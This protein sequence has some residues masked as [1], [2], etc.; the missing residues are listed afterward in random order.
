MT[1]EQINYLESFLSVMT[2]SER[3]HRT[4][5]KA[6]YDTDFLMKTFFS[7]RMTHRGKMIESCDF[8]HKIDIAYQ[9]NTDVN[10]IAPR[11]HAKTTRIIVN[12]FRDLA[13]GELIIW[14]P[15][16]LLYLSERW[17]GE[18]SI[19]RL[20]AELETNEIIRDV[21]WVLAPN[22]ADSKYI[23]E[24]SKKKRKQ[25]YLELT[26][27]ASIE[28]VSKWWALR[29]RRKHKVI[30]DDLEENK[31][32]KNLRVVEE[33]RDFMLTTVYNMMLP[34]GSM[35]ILGTIVGELCFVLYLKQKRAKAFNTLIVY[36]IQD[37]KPIRPAM[38]SKAALRKRL[39]TI[40][41]ARFMQEFMHKPISVKDRIIK[42]H[43]IKYRTTDTLPNKFDK[44][45]MGIDIATTEKKTS[46]ETAVTVLWFIFHSNRWVNYYDVYVL[47]NDGRKLSP[48]KTELMI[49]KKY[50]DRKPDEIYYEENIEA[51]LLEDLK[52][53][54]LPI[55]W[56]RTAK[57]KHTR[58]WD[59]APDI[60]FG[61]VFFWPDQKWLTDQL[62]YFPDVEHDDRMDSFLIALKRDVK[63][64]NDKVRA[65]S[66]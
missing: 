9:S 21:Y 51:K 41:S 24:N 1:L 42:A 3:R 2:R 26:N 31:D 16:D 14:E 29:G 35:F 62:T 15:Y 17:L 30:G 18:I 27:G 39:E 5:C 7:K 56:V 53:R 66:N 22:D 59:A 48:W 36:A 43:R 20:R 11:W 34:W 33:F 50:M 63:K 25:S 10:L 12:M 45:I 8:H 44:I 28:T 38:R 54:K 32:V 52:A 64:V 60:E 61:R 65:F 6:F 57:D 40:W 13:Y 37:K 46:D 47:H 58:L 19:G 49:V 55:K 23:V 4:Y